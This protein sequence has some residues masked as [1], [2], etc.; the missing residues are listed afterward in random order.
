MRLLSCSAGL[1]ALVSTIASTGTALAQD[2][3]AKPVRILAAAA[4]GG[5][6]FDARQI[7]QGIAGP[8]GQPVIV[9][10]RAQGA[11]A[12]EAGSKAAPDGYTLLV[13]GGAVWVGPLLRKAPY[14]VLTDFAP[15]A[16][17]ERGVNVLAVHPSLPV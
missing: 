16:L 7:A 15:I 9:D 14:D 8:L 12:A 5:N 11:L 1:L 10:N 4:G 13:A 2:Y 6:D 17:I 3:P